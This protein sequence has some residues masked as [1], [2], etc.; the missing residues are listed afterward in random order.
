MQIFFV[1]L[2]LVN[3]S[4]CLRPIKLPHYKQN[5]IRNLRKIC[6]LPIWHDNT[7]IYHSKIC[8]RIRNIDSMTTSDSSNTIVPTTSS[9]MSTSR[10]FE[11]EVTNTEAPVTTST[12]LSTLEVQMEKS[13][14]IQK[15]TRCKVIFQPLFLSG[16]IPT[17]LCSK[18]AL[19]NQDEPITT[20]PSI[21]HLT[22]KSMNKEHIGFLRN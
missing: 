7:H 16:Y 4:I 2:L 5:K 10:R 14:K 19:E 22:T 6:T 1:I 20:K 11:L 21:E 17:V 15:S 8:T 3:T 12:E 9:V 18:V 13:E